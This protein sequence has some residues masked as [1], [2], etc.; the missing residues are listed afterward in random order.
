MTAKGNICSAGIIS[1]LNGTRFSLHLGDCLEWMDSRP[2]NSVHAV[3]TDPPYGLKEYTQEE[4]EKL[5]KGKG[6]IWR[7]PPSYDGCTRSP[8]P[9]FTVLSEGELT[10]LRSFFSEFAKR[11]SRILVPGGHVFIATN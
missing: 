9:R 1:C 10:D 2:S 6:G 8:L 7:I 4:K 11:V 5:R 3:V